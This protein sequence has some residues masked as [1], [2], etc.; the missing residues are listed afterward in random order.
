MTAHRGTTA[1]AHRAT[2]GVVL[3]VLLAAC[4]GGGADEPTAT[5][6][7]TTSS[8]ATQDPTRQEPPVPEGEP[9]PTLAVLPEVELAVE[10]VAT[11]L[12]APWG[13]APLPDGTL[14]VSLRD[15]R[16]LVVVDPATGAV[17]AVS[18][19]GAD[20]LRDGTVTGGEAG[21]LGLAVGP[22][23]GDAPGEVFVYRTAPD[24][25]E[26]LRGTLAGRELSA[27]TPVVQG[28]PAASTHD[29]G[30]IAFGPDGYLYVATGDA[31]Q[32]GTSQ[33]PA[34]LGGKIL[35][36][37]VDGAPAPGNPDPASPV[38][39]LG[40]RNVQGLAWDVT[41]R[42]LA[43]EFGQDTFDEL[44]VIVPGG[45]YGWPDVEG[46]GGA[47]AGFVDPVATWATDDASPSGLA[48]TREGAYLAGLR[49]QALLR[50]PFV[51]PDGGT[52]ADA[53]GAPQS[54]LTDHGRLRAV[55]T[56]PSTPPGEDGSAVLF[57][58]TS[59]TDGR[60]DPRDGDDRLLRVTVTPAG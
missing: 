56:D 42:M 8:P 20:D 57:V 4:T 22:P 47:G 60:G 29:G 23:D 28:I 24:G 13:L 14:L 3:L 58:L 39:S 7:G 1:R 18:G 17:E 40:H 43:S 26:V 48:V 38:W 6:S 16:E 54:L 45:N 19:P 44:N 25:N 33:D 31:Q 15:A 12:D 55:L 37:T 41:G 59:N 46:T 50:V 51:T 11:G 30:R 32:E 9:A 2:A 49:G 36:V 10:D 34:S 52:S 53:F 21:L 35:R 27:L 5:P